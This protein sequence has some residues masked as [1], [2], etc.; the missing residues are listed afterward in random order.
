MLCIFLYFSQY[1]YYINLY[2]VFLCRDT[3]TAVREFS[4]DTGVIIFV[5]PCR[6][7]VDIVPADTDPSA[8]TSATLVGA[9]F[10]ESKL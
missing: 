7:A 1:K 8:V 2:S 10:L 4:M 3:H 9:A 5:V 6:A